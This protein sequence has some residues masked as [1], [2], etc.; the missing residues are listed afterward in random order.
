MTTQVEATVQNAKPKTTA[1]ISAVLS[2]PRFGPLDPMVIVTQTMAECGISFSAVGGALWGAS[3]EMQIV[4]S[5]KKSP[6]F[7]LTIDFDSYFTP[8]HVRELC[9]LMAEHPEADVV[10]PVQ[11]RRSDNGP[12][13][14]PVKDGKSVA[15]MTLGEMDSYGDMLEVNWS[16][17]GLTMIRASAF[18][19]LPHPWFMHQPDEA[20]MWGEN[21]IDDDI[22]FWNLLR[23]HG[24]R[25][26]VAHRLCIGH[27]SQQIVFPDKAFRPIYQSMDQFEKNGPPQGI[28]GWA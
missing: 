10:A 20:G 2:R 15:T 19:G 23:K 4:E 25:C 7:I 9:R 17:L 21:R 16:H 28:R 11:L 18:A 8:K 22:W 5:L 6:D 26:F 1:M 24:R 27:V 12:L 3:L 13:F 14:A